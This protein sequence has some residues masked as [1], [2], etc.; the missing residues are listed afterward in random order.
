MPQVH[1]RQP[2]SEEWA[3]M[4]P[5]ERVAALTPEELEGL[6]QLVADLPDYILPSYPFDLPPHRMPLA[7]YVLGE[8]GA[9]R[10]CPEARCR[11]AKSCRGGEGPP[12][13]RADREPLRQVLFLT[14]MLYIEHFTEEDVAFALTDSQNRYEVFGI[15]AQPVR[16]GEQPEPARPARRLR[17]S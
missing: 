16:G 8:A 3:G 2:T 12:G 5:E 1:G 4:T 9:W 14:H 17:A 6:R 7:Q 15:R 13:F 10:H 11:R